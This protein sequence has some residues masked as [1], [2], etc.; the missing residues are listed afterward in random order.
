MLGAESPWGNQTQT[1]GKDQGA[2]AGMGFR[3]GLERPGATE[4]QG[5]G[6]QVEKPSRAQGGLP[7]LL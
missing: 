2:D 6:F 4:P 7:L 3:V 1:P 5:G